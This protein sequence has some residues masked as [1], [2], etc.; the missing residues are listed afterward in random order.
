MNISIRGFG[1]MGRNHFKICQ[2][3]KF[4]IVAIYDPIH[5]D[6]YDLYE[7]SLKISDA[8][9]IASPTGHHLSDINHALN[10]NPKIKILCEKP[11][12]INAKDDV[13]D[14]LPFEKQILVG[15]IERFNPII[16]YIKK[17]IQYENIIQ[18]K[19]TRISN[20]PARENINIVKDIGIHDLD[21]C[22]FLINKYPKKINIQ[23]K[24]KNACHN[25]IFY[26]ID[27]IQINNE[28]SWKY[29]YK[30]RE[31]NILTDNGI[32]NGNYFNQTL[33]F[34]DWSNN[35]NNIAIERIEPL[36]CEISFLEK[37]VLNNTDSCVTITSNLHLLKLIDDQINE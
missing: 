17:N 4:N 34:T 3:K 20:T 2:N 37:M 14:I 35:K 29:P 1:V 9:I 27:N 19:T 32:Y 10:I 30:N 24:N 16:S 31:I 13:K 22:Y 36:F 7:R 28:I 5:Y 18:I 33:S 8:L 23:N 11:I 26:N 21:I 12:T 15:Q 25:N 6:D